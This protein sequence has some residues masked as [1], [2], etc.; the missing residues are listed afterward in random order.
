MEEVY[1]VKEFYC[2]VKKVSKDRNS[3]GS[4]YFYTFCSKIE[5]FL[6]PFIKYRRMYFWSIGYSSRRISLSLKE[7]N[8]NRTE[9][10]W[11]EYLCNGSVNNFRNDS[12]RNLI[13]SK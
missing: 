4:C 11:K 10:F 7:K 9:G 12:T 6:R 1:V 3:N 8:I 13:F 2:K 5:M